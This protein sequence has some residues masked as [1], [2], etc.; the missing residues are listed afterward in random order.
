MKFCPNCGAQIPDNANFCPSCGTRFGAAPQSPYQQ[1]YQQPQYQQP[2]QQ[3]A[4][5]KMTYMDKV[6][7]AREAQKQK[8]GQIKWWMWALIGI[9]SAILIALNPL[10]L[11]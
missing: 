5:L 6:R 10:G 9:G 1:P 4:P 2:Y 3:P 7:A 8:N 11:S